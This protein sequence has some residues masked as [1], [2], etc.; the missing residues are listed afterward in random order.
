[1]QCRKKV[2]AIFRVEIEK[3][4]SRSEETIT[5]LLDGIKQIK[6]EEGNKLSDQEVLDNII[7]LVVGGYES[8]TLASMWA[9][10]YLAKYPIV[11]KK[12]RV[13]TSSVL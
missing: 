5:D 7:A 4:K 2:E 1:M 12:L 6:D 13:L 9:I 10:Y 11:L 8:T 3:R